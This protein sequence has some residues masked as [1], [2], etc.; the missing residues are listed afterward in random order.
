MRTA[1]ALALL[2]V[3]AI[4]AYAVNASIPGLDLNMVGTVLTLVG[5]LWL[6]VEIGLEVAAM[7]R[8]RRPEEPRERRPAPERE[9]APARPYDPVIRPRQGDRDAAARGGPARSDPDDPTRVMPR[10][11]GDG[12][13]GRY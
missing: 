2:T 7:P 12:R 10:Q 5:L 3:G 11:S 4:L 1:P 13:S 6:L 8:R 9:P